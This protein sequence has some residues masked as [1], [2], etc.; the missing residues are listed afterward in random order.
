MHSQGRYRDAYDKYT[1]AIK[2][3]PDNAILYC[4][5]AAASMLTKEY[6]Y[7]FKSSFRCVMIHSYLDV[8]SDAEKVW[9][10]HVMGNGFINKDF[11]QAVSLDP[12]YYKAWARAA[13][14]SYASGISRLIHVA[15]IWHHRH[16]LPGRIVSG[17]T[18][19]H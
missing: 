4:N 15:H 7:I 12:T 13:K 18:K 6:V 11:S 19:T 2:L 3:A 5:R 1:E 8:C 10:I 9:F 16:C 14:A 17:H